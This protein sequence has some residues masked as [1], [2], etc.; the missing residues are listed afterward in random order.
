MRDYIHRWTML[1]DVVENVTKHQAVCAF[2][3]GVRYRELILKLGCSGTLCMSRMT[4]IATLYVNGKE[5]DRL[6]SGKGKASEHGTKNNY[7]SWKQ[8]HKAEGTGQA[9]AT[10]L[11][12]QGKFKGK[13]EEQ[14]IPKKK[15]QQSG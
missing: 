3:D 8:K 11:A 9:D 5:E 1:H 7:P 4:E 12:T 15:R 10:A 2:K 14:W 6:C 13:A